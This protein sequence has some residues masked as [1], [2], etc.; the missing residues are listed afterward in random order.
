VISRIQGRGTQLNNGAHASS[1]EVLVFLH[2]DTSVPSGFFD[3]LEEQ[4]RDPSLQCGAFQTN[5]DPP[6][7]VLRLYSWFTR[8]E[9]RFTTFGDQCLIVRR[10]FFEQLGG[11]PPWPLFE[12]MEFLRRVRGMTSIRKFPVKVV[13]S[14]RKFRQGGTILQQIR[15][16]V[17]ITMVHFGVSP[18]RLYSRYYGKNQSVFVPPQE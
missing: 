17:T 6:S 12:D 18:K 2:A 1:G 13:T 4:L 10:P 11:F 14:A 3:F 15:N 9:T 7:P 5:Y 16:G 8:F